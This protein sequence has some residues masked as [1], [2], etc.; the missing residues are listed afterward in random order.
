M[1]RLYHVEERDRGAAFSLKG[2]HYQENGTFYMF[3]TFN[4]QVCWLRT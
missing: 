4:R 1:L 2:L 3:G